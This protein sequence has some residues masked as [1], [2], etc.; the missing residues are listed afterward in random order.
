MSFTTFVQFSQA[1][2]TALLMRTTSA[3]WVSNS[4]CLITLKSA[5]LKS[6]IHLFVFVSW[7]RALI[8][9]HNTVWSERKSTSA[10]STGLKLSAVFVKTMSKMLLCTFEK[11]HNSAESSYDL[12][13]TW[14]S[15]LLNTLMTIIIPWNIRI[16]ITQQANFLYLLYSVESKLRKATLKSIILLLL[17][18]L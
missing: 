2:S 6:C 7:V 15:P 10:F 11:K 4:C 12:P 3:R 17:G 18:D 5:A 8:P 16:K 1:L 9:K 14:Q 13:S